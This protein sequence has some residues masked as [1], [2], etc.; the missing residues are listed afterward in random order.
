[1]F[2][3]TGWFMIRRAS[4]FSTSTLLATLLASGLVGTGCK[5][6][7]I[8]G[9][10]DDGDT[11]GDSPDTPLPSIRDVDVLFVID[12]TFSTGEEQGKFAASLGAF[13][14]VLEDP[15]LDLNYRIA[16]TTSDVGNPRCDGTTPEKG[17]FVYASCRDRLADFVSLDLSTD[18]GA[19]ACTD[20]CTK[21]SAELGITADSEPWL[22]V[23]EGAANLPAG[24]TTVEA[25]ECLAPQGINGC[26]FESHLEAM[27]LALLRTESQGQ[28]E[29]GFVRDNALLA[30]VVLTDEADCSYHEGLADEI[31]VDNPVF[32]YDGPG[33]LPYS[34]SALCWNAGVKCV[35]NG[36]ALDCEPADYG[37]DGTE[38]DDPLLAEDQAV[39]HPV[40]RYIARVQ[41]IENVKKGANRNQEVVVALIGGVGDDGRPL[42][43][44]S[45]DIDYMANFGI[46]PG[47]SA[48][49][50]SSTP[51]G[52][53]ADCTGFGTNTCS[54]QGYCVA[55]QTGIPPVRLAAFT[56]SF[57][58]DAMF[59]I[60]N[61]SLDDALVG[62][63]ERII[64]PMVDE[65]I[66][67][68]YNDCAADRD[69]STP[70]LVD[71]DCSVF[72]IVD[73][74]ETEMVECRRDPGGNGYVINDIGDYTMPD[75]ATVVCYAQL[76]DAGGT[77]P[78]TSD[79]LDPECKAYGYNLSFAV[80][81]RRGFPAPQGA[82]ATVRCEPSEQ[83][84]VDCP[85]L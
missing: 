4:L 24:V 41:G 59:S 28:P 12:N 82:A 31:F 11:E 29:S 60:C 36:G 8:G 26:G 44:N 66:T 64:E 38:I 20:R 54:P 65:L 62:V 14:S 21:S 76:G 3:S 70:Q 81:R 5:G 52:S 40:S 49:A 74:T 18:A 22:E 50:E 35:D 32:W 72:E 57:T 1:M 53:D 42:Y 37:L 56:E 45:P 43:Q 84:S 19:F 68:C 13:V 34:T 85:N 7:A 55:E 27:N 51:C 6:R 69:P 25:L 78:S 83:P 30:I 48:V 33:A 79:D 58:Q 77:T 67:G 73:D 39:L 46:G 2:A 17:S 80:V 71:A 15:A 47:C 9:E 16:F 61:P 10:S 75:D 23:F 63:A